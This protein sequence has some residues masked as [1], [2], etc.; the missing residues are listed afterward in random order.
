MFSSSIFFPLDTQVLISSL[1][2]LLDTLNFFLSLLKDL[3]LCIC[4]QGLGS[5]SLTEFF[6]LRTNANYKL[7]SIAFPSSNFI[8]VNTDF[9]ARSAIDISIVT[10]TPK[11]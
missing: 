7:Y 10:V 4:F 6:D 11:L 1:Q 8:A 5:F 9:N 2:T 3:H